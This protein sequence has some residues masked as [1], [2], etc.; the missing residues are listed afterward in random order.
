MESHGN[1]NHHRQ[2]QSRTRGFSLVVLPLTCRRTSSRI[3][4]FPT[5]LAVAPTCLTTSTYSFHSSGRVGVDH[6]VEDEFVSKIRSG[7]L[8]LAKNCLSRERQ[9]SSVRGR[10]PATWERGMADTMFYRTRPES[11]A[12]AS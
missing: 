10:N 11:S 9:M 4:P 3:C 6:E 8:R 12:D 1:Q 2:S 5:Y 7:F